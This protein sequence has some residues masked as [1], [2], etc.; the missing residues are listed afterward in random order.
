M[1][2]KRTTTVCLSIFIV[3][4]FLVGCKGINFPTSPCTNCQDYTTL[5]GTI[6]DAITGE[7]LGGTDME[8][9]LI[10]GGITRTPTTFNTGVKLK[11][12]LNRKDNSTATLMGE[13]SFTD[14]PSETTYYD[15]SNS[16]PLPGEDPDQENTREYKIVVKKPGFQE[17]NGIVEFDDEANVI[18]NIYLFPVGYNTPDYTF[19]IVCADGGKPVPNATVLF[20]PQAANN[21]MITSDDHVLKPSSGYLPSLQAKSDANGMVTFQGSQLAL[22]ARYALT[23]LPIKFE[24]ITLGLNEYGTFDIGYTAS[25]NV[26]MI[27]LDD[28]EDYDYGLYVTEISNSAY[29]TVDSTGALTITFNRAVT[30]GT[31]PAPATANFGATS[32][33]PTGVLDATAP[34]TAV[35]ST[36][37]LT[38]TLTPVW[39][40]VPA[41]TDYGT[42]ITYLN[43]TGYLS[44][45][46][47]PGS[48][49]HLT[50][51][52]DAA[53]DSISRTVLLTTP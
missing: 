40:T 11:G 34:V 25:Y 38:L 20:Q 29:D 16:Q 26:D 10:Q 4:A 7:R 39:T 27:Y 31:R 12:F 2:V 53:G 15:D 44:V 45:A 24:G 19:T 14:I 23:V 46:G 13:Y 5:Q 35:L 51:L 1:N 50:D 28:L 49:I 52:Q 47:Y 41:A 48:E 6:M 17:F 37:G 30:L 36:D 42:S 18:G 8:I 9:Y 33:S 43:G 32:T 22:G 21:D 3:C